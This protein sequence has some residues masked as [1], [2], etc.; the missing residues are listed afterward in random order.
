MKVT[1][2]LGYGFLYFQSLAAGTYTI[3]FKPSWGKMD[4]R[5]YTI[6]VYAP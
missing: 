6:S 3:T 1:D 2:Q 5:D 4:I